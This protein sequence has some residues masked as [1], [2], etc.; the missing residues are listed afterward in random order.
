MSTSFGHEQRERRFGV[1]V[2][3]DALL[4]RS[5]MLVVHNC[6][7]IGRM[8]YLSHDVRDG[9]PMASTAQSEAL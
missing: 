3:V 7:S 5:V 1:V 6:I 4:P 9:S 2:R 8:V